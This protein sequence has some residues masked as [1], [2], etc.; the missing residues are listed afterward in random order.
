MSPLF[1]ISVLLPLMTLS[2][3]TSADVF[4]RRTE[5]GVVTAHPAATAAAEA[6][7]KEGGSAAD[8]A[9]GAQMVLGVVEPQSSG[10]GGGAIV[11]Y[12]TPAR[13]DIVALDGL[14]KSPAG[15][16]QTLGSRSNF[17][18]S[19]ASVGTPG[20]VRAMYS[21]HSRFGKLPWAR[22]FE[23][24]IDLAENGFPVPPYL[25]RS[26]AA[27]TKLG[28][29][30]PAW[31]R[32][33]DGNP[34]EEG[35]MVRN[36]KLASTLRLISQKG[37]EAFYVDMAP[38]IVA[39]VNGTQLPGKMSESD[40]AAYSA[41]ERTALCSKYKDL[42]VCTF[43]PPSFGGL[44]VLETIGIL[45]RVSSK[46]VDFL[47]PDFVHLFVEAGRI[48]EADR[49]Q[50]V[51]D[52]DKGAPSVIGLLGEQY[53]ARRASEIKHDDVLKDPIAVGIPIDCT[54]TARAPGPSTSQ[55][56]IVDSAGAALSM[57]T[58]ININFGSW[59]EV[60]GFFLNDAMTN[61]SLP[62]D[63]TCP[64]NA[65]GPDKRPETSMAPIIGVEPGG[66]VVVVGGS[67]GGGEIVDYVAQALM[68]IID[69]TSPLAA[70]D[71]G[72][73]STAR[74]PYPGSR[75]EIDLETGRGISELADTLKTF[76]H[77]TRSKALPSGLGFLAWRN[78]WVGAADPRRDGIVSTG[79][80][81]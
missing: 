64:A 38:A 37:P 14:A 25:A 11:L 22:L 39:A 74:S 16:D 56:V 48:A 53:L 43:P 73:V 28:F 5:Y 72:H 54:S 23:P 35:T 9:I 77:A 59:I 68:Q 50:I 32:S 31:F 13:G 62:A 21:L 24:A 20:I 78:A 51:G 17:S 57:T 45:E 80:L 55:I 15:Y 34:V 30:P 75:G 36:A 6:L 8:A 71:S 76:G 58:T 44:A 40:L 7:L 47:N 52:P 70:L 1:I 12:V 4:S 33:P 10:L 42:K 27:S 29:F 19:G 81:P 3:R 61:F 65:P 66:K 18:H 41:V 46:S 67:A 26:L 60:G 63:G 69:G 49:M 79:H 2:V